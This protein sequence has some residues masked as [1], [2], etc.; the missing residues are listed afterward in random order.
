MIPARPDDFARAWL[1]VLGLPAAQAAR[2]LLGAS[3]V[4]RDG[5]VVTLVEVEAYGGIG[6]DPASH[7]YRGRTARNAPMFGP[8]GHLYVYL[9][10]GIHR[11]VNVVA[12]EPGTASAVLLRAARVDDGE[13]LVR[14]RRNAPAA[15]HRTLASGPGRLGQALG[16]T[17]GDSGAGMRASDAPL[18]FATPPAPLAAAAIATGPRIGISQG[19]ELPWRLWIRGH[20][21]VS[22]T[23]T[24]VTAAPT[25]P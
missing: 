15:P 25:V 18:R 22:R 17:L 1:G 11:C 3:L 19:R 4:S 7:A 6:E 16:L 21:A 12:H 23:P 20:P 2:A 13:P 24:P 5:I 9:S 8:P 10:Y 14:S